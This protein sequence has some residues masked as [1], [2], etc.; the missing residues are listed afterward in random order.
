MTK[1]ELIG[2]LALRFPQLVAKDADYA[3]NMI[4]DAMTEALARGN[5]IEIRG[6]GSFA[7]NYRPP[8]IGRNPKSGDKV[9]VPS[10]YVP[11]FKAGKELRERVD[12]S[13]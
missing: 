11:H 7:L 10:K 1:S 6:F 9:L 12:Q 5:R 2:R 8:R 4:L 3:V 13:E